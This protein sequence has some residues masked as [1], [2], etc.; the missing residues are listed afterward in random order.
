MTKEMT[1]PPQLPIL[2]AE[3]LIAQAVD[4]G[5]PIETMERLLSMREKIKAE[6]AREAY[7][8]ALSEFLSECP[9]IEKKRKVRS[10]DGTTRYSYATLDDIVEQVKPFLANYGISYTIK[11][12]VEKDSIEAITETHHVQGHTESSSFTVPI[13]AE[14]YM[15]EAQ[16][17]GSA[18][19]YAKRYSFCN[20]LGILTGD[21]DDDASSLGGGVTVE[22]LYARFSQ[23]MKA[24]YAYHDSIVAIKEAMKTG[25]F[26]AGA[27]AWYELPNEIKAHISIAPSKGGILT[28]SERE[29]LKSKAWH[30]SF[31]GPDM[32]KNY[33]P[34][35]PGK[36]DAVKAAK[37]GDIDLARD[38]ASHLSDKDKNYVENVIN[39]IT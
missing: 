37:A 8:T 24:C 25:E 4:K 14:A 1:K 2:S 34:D 21:E 33:Q 26:S 9:I 10:K 31:Y 38:I 29:M 27:E 18:L 22:Q 36:D 39:N 32:G 16:K 11:T 30:E 17:S 7:F 19:T 13:A 35:K 12:K 15:N 23:T 20:A 28:T 6:Q 5:V 3:N